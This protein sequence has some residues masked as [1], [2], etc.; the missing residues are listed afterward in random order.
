MTPTISPRHLGTTHSPWLVLAIE[1]FYGAV[2]LISSAEKD[3]VTLMA[4]TSMRVRALS[5]DC[6]RLC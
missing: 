1:I 2:R 6:I 3:W 4:Y 5:G